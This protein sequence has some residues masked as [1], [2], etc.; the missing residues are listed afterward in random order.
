MQMFI[1]DVFNPS[2]GMFD[3][4]VMY[5]TRLELSY[6]PRDV[7]MAAETKSCCYPVLYLCMHIYI[8]M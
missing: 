5:L 1:V 7:C 3:A 8:Y 4:D 2:G 6:S